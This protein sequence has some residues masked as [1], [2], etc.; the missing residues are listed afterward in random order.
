MSRLDQAS[1]AGAWSLRAAIGLALYATAGGIVSFLG[2][3]ADVPRLTDWFNIGISIQPNAALAVVLAGAGLLALV[4]G[5]R[6]L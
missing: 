6:H 2:W 1:Q 4:A 5:L 3:A